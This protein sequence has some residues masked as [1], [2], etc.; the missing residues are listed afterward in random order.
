[1]SRVI[2]AVIS[3]VKGTYGIYLLSCIKVSAYKYISDKSIAFYSCLSDDSE[4]FL[5][6]LYKVVSSYDN[7]INCGFQLSVIQTAVSSYNNNRLS[8]F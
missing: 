2:R 3:C 8:G 5:C 4:F 7:D 1:M 6:D